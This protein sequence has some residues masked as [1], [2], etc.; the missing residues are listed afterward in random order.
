MKKENQKPRNCKLLASCSQGSWHGHSFET[1][2][3]YLH[4]NRRT[5]LHPEKNLRF[6]HLHLVA[7]EFC[8]ARME[9]G[10]DILLKQHSVVWVFHPVHTDAPISTWQ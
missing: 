1:A 4:M 3:K 10:V 6:G 9:V 8:Y 5:I 2:F 7:R